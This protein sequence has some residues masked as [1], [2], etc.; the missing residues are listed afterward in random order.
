MTPSQFYKIIMII[1]NA[2]KKIKWDEFHKKNSEKIIN[3]FKKQI[4][5]EHFLDPLYNYI[6]DNMG[7]YRI[8]K[9]WSDII[10][11]SE[12]IKRNINPI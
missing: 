8:G 5:L 12:V 3:S 6:S 1:L 11:R 10:T 2:K 4:T 9:S 7:W